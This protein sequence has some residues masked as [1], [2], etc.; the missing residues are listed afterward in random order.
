MNNYN[1]NEEQKQ[2]IYEKDLLLSLIKNN[3]CTTFDL[4]EMTG[5]AAEK[6]SRYLTSLRYYNLIE[7][8]T[9]EQQ[10]NRLL[11]KYTATSE[12]TFHETLVSSLVDAQERRVATRLAAEE[13]KRQMQKKKEKSG[14]TIVT[15]NDYHTKGNKQKIENWR[16]YTSFK[17]S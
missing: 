5:F 6:V 13:Q 16:G 15:S 9:A 1:F 2:Q 14:I 3:P 12:K 8:E 4:K 11:R 17:E 7:Q 10:P